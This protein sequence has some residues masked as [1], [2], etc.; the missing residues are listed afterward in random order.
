MAT[1]ARQDARAGLYALLT[2]FHTAN[3]T[4][5]YS[6]YLSRPAGF[7]PELPAGFVGAM[8]EPTIRH[9]SGTRQRNFGLEIVLIDNFSPSNEAQAYRLD[10][11][12]DA[13][14]DYCTAN[15]Q[16]VAHT[17]LAPTSVSEGEITIAGGTQSITYR[18]VSVAIQFTIMEG[19]N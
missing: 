6:A 18:A 9:D 19:R 4:L 7:S 12:V 16:I 8:N 13:F 10:A 14:V 2:G 11:L 15:P 17:I 3:P 5:L 1:T